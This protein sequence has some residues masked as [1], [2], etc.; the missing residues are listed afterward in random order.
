MIYLDKYGLRTKKRISYTLWKEL[1]ARILN[2]EHLDPDLAPI[3][4]YLASKINN[5]WY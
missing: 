5:T 2:K 4:K 1:H 3:I